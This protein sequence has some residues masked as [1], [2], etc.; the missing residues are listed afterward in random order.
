MPFVFR[1][2]A[3]RTLG[4]LGLLLAATTASAQTISPSS[5]PASPEFLSNY[6]F[7]LGMSKLAIDDQRFSSDAHYGGDI[8]LVDY[9]VG[10]VNFLADYETVLGTEYRPFD[11]NQ[12]NYVLEGSLSA[13]ARQTEFQAVFH[14]VSRHLSDRPKRFGVGWN[15][16]GVRGLRRFDAG[17]WT[18]DGQAF[19]GKVLKSYF[20]DYAWTGNADVLCRRP[21]RNRVGAFVHAS[22]QLFGVDPARLHRSAQ[23]D[24][25]VES[26]L[27]LEGR[28][29]A[30]ELFVGLERRIDAYPIDREAKHWVMAGFR[31]VN[32]R[33]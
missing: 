19:A 3:G 31:L 23:A 26:G 15:I 12:A 2:V 18:I 8:D 20:A 1:N 10:R 16:V 7:H 5:A 6:N 11:P 9:V 33:K 29:G 14:H 25:L 22:G 24:G 28:A 21:I 27:R 32:L 13:R 17:G 30:V 4:V